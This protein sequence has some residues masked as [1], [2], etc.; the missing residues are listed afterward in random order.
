[1][2]DELDTSVVGLK[3]FL[4]GICRWETV[5]YRSK[6]AFSR[7]TFKQINFEIM[8]RIDLGFGTTASSR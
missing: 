5:D 4:F 6:V 2:T 7:I 1:M 8:L 3:A